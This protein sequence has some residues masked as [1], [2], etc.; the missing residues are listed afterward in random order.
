M[1]GNC[2]STSNI[3]KVKEHTLP[4]ANF[5]VSKSSICVGESFDLIA[6]KYTNAVYDWKRD[7]ISISGILTE[8]ISQNQAGDYQLFIKDENDCEA[9]SN[10]ETISQV[11]AVVIR[12]DPIPIVCDPSVPSIALSAAPAG[13][14]FSG[15]GVENNGKFNPKIAG[16]G[17]HNLKYTLTG[18][19]NSCLNGS[20]DI[21][22]IVSKPPTT[23]LP[24][25]LNIASGATIELNGLSP[26]GVLYAWFPTNGITNPTDGKTKLKT[27]VNSTYKLN[28]KN[29]YGCENN[30]EVKI[31]VEQRVIVPTALTPNGDGTNDTWEIF[32]IQGYP[33]AEILIYNRWGEPVFHSKG[34]SQ[35]FD[36][37]KEGVPLP[38]GAY[39]YT[40]ILD[41]TKRRLNGTLT[42]LR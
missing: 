17:Q 42:I 15:N 2:L 41:Q 39:T 6:N 40:I 24:A 29:V 28:I 9:T 30:Y 11:S 20:K 22:V 36:G 14:T 12:F 33:D 19:T 5:A 4:I 10:T 16:I 26:D 23:T 31:Y 37:T 1:A 8:K 32:N 3:F 21:N 18:N 13:G 27:T 34:Y 35:P 25:I 38:E 7:G